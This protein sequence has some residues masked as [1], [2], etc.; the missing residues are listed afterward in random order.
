MRGNKSV[1][2]KCQ[3]FRVS[4]SYCHITGLPSSVCV[5]YCASV[6]AVPVIIVGYD[7]TGITSV[8]QTL[9]FGFIN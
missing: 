8:L 2:G 1:L 4:V 3:V 6:M 7:Q 5:V 9:R